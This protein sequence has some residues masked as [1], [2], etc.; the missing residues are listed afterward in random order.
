MKVVKV[1]DVQEEPVPSRIKKLMTPGTVTQQVFDIPKGNFTVAKIN[2]GRGVRNKF[3]THTSDQILIITGG[4][5]IVATE[6]EETMVEPGDIVFFPAGEKHWHGATPD[7]DFS[8]IFITAYGHKT[9]QL[10]E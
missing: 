8:H 10:E 2:F 1:E 6:K 4:K 3:H 9:T 7:S 5:G